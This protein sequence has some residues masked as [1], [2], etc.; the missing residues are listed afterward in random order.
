[1]T[2]GLALSVALLAV[3][4]LPLVQSPENVGATVL[5]LHG[6]HDLRGAYQALATGLR[7]GAIVVGAPFGVTEALLGLVL[8]QVLATAC[9]SV[10]GALALTA[11]ETN[12][13]ADPIVQR[14]IADLPLPTFPDR[15][16]DNY[17]ATGQFEFDYELFLTAFV[18]EETSEPISNATA[19]PSSTA[20]TQAAVATD[21]SCGCTRWARRSCAHNRGHID[22]PRPSNSRR[23]C[24]NQG[25]VS[26]RSRAA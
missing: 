15:L 4:L 2:R 8:A 17:F 7:L 23:D 25:G 3:A 18:D 22:R 13:A 1:M 5:L 6:R 26:R 20:Q 16:S 19:S 10:A 9:V 21:P 24:G 14:L 11:C 12:D